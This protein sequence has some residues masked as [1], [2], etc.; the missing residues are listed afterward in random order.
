ME[1]DQKDYTED[2]LKKILKIIMRSVLTTA[3]LIIIFY[4]C[5]KRYSGLGAA[6]SKIRTV[7]RPI[8][9]G[10][11]L[12]FFMNP[13][14]E[15]FQKGMD[16]FFLP[17]VKN[18]KKTKRIIRVISSII[19][20]III[21][22]LIIVF[23]V[24][25]IPQIVTTLT[26]IYNHLEDQLKNVLKWANDITG[27]RFASTLN[28]ASKTENINNFIGKAKD[29]LAK[30]MKWDGRTEMVTSITYSV[31]DVGKYIVSFF[32]GIFVGIYF[33]IDKEKYKAIFK[34]MLFNICPP[35]IVNPV[36]DVIRK[37]GDIFY[38]FFVGKIIDSIIIGLICYICMLIFRMPYPVLVSVIIG[39]TN[40]I[41]VFGPYIGAIPSVTIIFFTNPMQGIYFLIFV[42]I[43]QQFDGNLIGPKIL[44]DS[45]GISAFWVLF[46]I[47][48]GGGLFGFMGMIF[49]VPVVALMYDI[50]SRFFVHLSE[51]KNMPS[52][53]KLYEKA[54]GI[55][56]ATGKIIY[57]EKKESK[58]NIKL[59]E[60]IRNLK[61][62]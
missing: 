59:F 43:L 29:F 25:V 40:V 28:D 46:A 1:E 19:S 39:V 35:K 26:Y 56:E 55:D 5:L 54:S 17:R 21:L 12:A 16:R 2:D 51:K 62:K 7:F 9:I 32:V 20:I 30:Y 34:K 45:T 53:T 38:G 13:V 44:G 27:K 8:V 11:F 47:V 23:L 36:M 15:F 24:S 52:S 49:G 31:I 10:F 61:R 57:Y 37:A 33:L 41:P 58:K 6:F 60:K 4:F 18:I 48:V 14:M 3:F 50:L 22:A 42:I